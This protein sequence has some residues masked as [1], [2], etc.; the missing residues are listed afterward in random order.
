MSK[1]RSRGGRDKRFIA[2][3]KRIQ[4][5]RMER[6]MSLRDLGEKAN[7]HRSYIVDIESGIVQIRMDTFF[8]IAKAFKMKPWELLK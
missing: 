4:Y 5:E 3:G 2:L 6:L 1:R 7:L 8:K